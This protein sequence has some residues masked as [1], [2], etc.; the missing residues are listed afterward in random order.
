MSGQSIER[1]EEV[2]T[3]R[4]Y[5]LVPLKNVVVFPRTRVNLTIVRPRS[6]QAVMEADKGSRIFVTAKQRSSD[7]D[8][9]QPEDIF[10][11][12]TVVQILSLQPQDNGVQL[13]VEGLRRV[14]IEE[15]QSR[16]PYLSVVATRIPEPTVTSPAAQALVRHAHELFE[17]YIQLNRRFSAQETDSIVSLRSPG[18]LADVLA[19]S[20]VNDHKQQQ[21]LLETT[22]PDQRLEKLCVILGNEIGVLELDKRI[23]ERVREQVDHNQKTYYLKEQLIAI[24]KE[25]GQD[26]ASEAQ[27]L[28]DRVAAKE[29]P[30][31]VEAK[32]LK[33]ITKLER[34][35]ANSAEI[36]VL[37]NYID[38]MLS[39]PWKERTDDQLETDEV[40]RVLNA[41][42]YG[43]VRVK[44]RITDFMA[45]RQLRLQQA[46]RRQTEGTDEEK[47]IA[48]AREVNR[49]PILCLIGPPGVGKTS[50]GESIA[51]AMRRNFIRISLGGVHDEAEIRGH[52][53]TYVGAMPG[54]I[55]HAMKTGGVR[56]PVFL[57][58]EIDKLSSDYRGDP[59]A[60]LLEVLDPAQN[61]SFTD[62]YLEVPYDLSEVFFICTGNNRYGIPRPLQDR[63]EIIELPGYTEEEKVSIAR[64]YIWPRVLAEHGLTKEHVRASDKII[65]WVIASY[66]REAGVRSLE[67]E[68]QA[69]CRKVARR[70]VREPDTHIRLTRKLVEEYLG[71]PRFTAT[72][73]IESDQIGVATGLAWTEMG[74]TLLPVEVAVVSGRG[75]VQLT[76]QQGEVMQESARAAHTYIRTRAEE[77]GISSTFADQVDM[78]VHLPEGAIPK[79]GPS[80]GITIATA[81]I[82]A[83]TRAPVRADTAMTGEITLRGRVL[84]IG[85][86]RDKVLAAH[87]AHIRRIILPAENKKDLGEI[88]EKVRSQMEFIF[89]SQMEEVEEAALRPP[90]PGPEQEEPSIL[91]AQNNGMA[92]QRGGET[93]INEPPPASH[94]EDAPATHMGRRKSAR[95][96]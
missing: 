42:H 12:A 39:L 82:S 33:E 6:V 53:R 48:A 74:G 46:M 66:T 78:H 76:G 3:M 31:E 34:T 51:H 17:S 38:W 45:V 75:T 73:P 57:L 2:D 14:H 7:T 41:E 92:T 22:D 37:R 16:E 55:I 94:H 95:Q 4:E 90:E 61:H 81:M 13:V 91:I 89:V 47:R 29:M 64:S 58:D 52:R 32:V 19:A 44:D 69:V 79:D 80:A 23:R 21:D 35:P 36:G 28:R 86:L 67:R 1:Q 59:S 63:M 27:E 25:L 54:R 72:P 9:P 68:M 70:V 26:V 50:L 88:P 24:Q 5:P 43:L 15:W 56:N 83:L 93:A 11:V 60:A 18:R 40:E 8:D 62:H 84:A 49:G 65:Q 20:L 85:G 30:P 96:R 87:R 77:L 10:T 71:V